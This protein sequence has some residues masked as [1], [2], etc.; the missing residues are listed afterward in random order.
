MLSWG[1]GIDVGFA[2]LSPSYGCSLP[3]LF[4]E[5]GQKAGQSVGYPGIDRGELAGCL[6][7]RGDVETALE[8][9]RCVLRIGLGGL[10]AGNDQIALPFGIAG[11]A[12]GQRL[13]DRE[14]G[15]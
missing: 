4:G 13:A 15:A 12:A 6:E 3:P 2:L 11:I 8:Q 1:G 7:L 5:F 14:A 9:R 10:H